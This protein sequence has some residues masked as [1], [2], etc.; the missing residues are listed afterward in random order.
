MKRPAS[1]P[2]LLL[3]TMLLL[4]LYVAA[5]AGA[6]PARTAASSAG[7]FDAYYT[8]VDSGEAFEKFSRTGPHAD[9]VVRNVGAAGGRLVF[10]R[11]TSFIPAWV[12]ENGIWYN[13]EFYETQ[14][15]TMTT[16]VEPMADKQARFS[17]PRILESHEA[18]VVVLAGPGEERLVAEVAGACATA[19]VGLPR[20]PMASTVQEPDEVSRT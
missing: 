4:A 8:K 15:G 12:T 3:G 19:V 17:H 10:W 16:S 18:R 9:I 13:N 5:I 11:G 7:S 14:D 20:K 6:E 2:V 1:I